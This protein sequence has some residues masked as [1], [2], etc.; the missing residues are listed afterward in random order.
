MSINASTHVTAGVAVAE[1]AVTGRGQGGV[2]DA[3]VVGVE[4]GRHEEP[5]V[6]D[7]TTCDTVS[8]GA[9]GA[10]G[11]TGGWAILT[12]ARIW[13]TVAHRGQLGDLG[14]VVRRGLHRHRG[15]IDGQAAIGEHAHRSPDASPWP[16]PGG[17]AR[18]RGAGTGRPATST[19]GSTSGPRPRSTRPSRPTSATRSTNAVCTALSCPTSTPRRV[20]MSSG[21]GSPVAHRGIVHMFDQCCQGVDGRD[22]DK[23]CHV[24]RRPVGGGWAATHRAP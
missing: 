2:D 9:S 7:R 6:S 20:S 8:S 12:M 4:L 3:A 14:I 5:A 19:S 23:G 18:R 21:I 10:A 13:V 15:L 1:Q 11:S 16:R 22:L 17:P 24:R